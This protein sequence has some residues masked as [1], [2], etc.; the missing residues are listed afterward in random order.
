MLKQ[1]AHQQLAR[2][3]DFR[4]SINTERFQGSFSTKKTTKTTNC[5]VHLATQALHPMLPSIATPPSATLP[6][7]TL[8]IGFWNTL[9]CVSQRHPTH[10]S[11]SEIGGFGVMCSKRMRCRSFEF[12]CIPPSPPPLPPQYRL[13]FLRDRRT[14]IIPPDLGAGCRFTVPPDPAIFL[15]APDANPPVRARGRQA[16]PV[17]AP[18]PGSPA[19]G[20][21]PRR[22][23][24][25]LQG[26][27]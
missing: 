4:F 11:T 10:H 15:L 1:L 27:E 21:A 16:C 24:R 18:T 7:E 2:C 26:D 22:H 20:T 6:I 13:Y 14:R 25:A 9:A 19:S 23:G 12:Q 17:P 5:K 3:L 8:K